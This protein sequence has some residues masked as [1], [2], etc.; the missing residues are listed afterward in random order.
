MSIN[1]TAVV[2]GVKELLRLA[3]F[4]GI[5]AGITYLTQVLTSLD[6]G[7]VEAIVLTLVLRFVDKYVN[8]NPSIK[9][10]GLAPF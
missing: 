7:S 2:E 8:K 1:K 4:A 5:A 10:N 9:H 3:L 6:P